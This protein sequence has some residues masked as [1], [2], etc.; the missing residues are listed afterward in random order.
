MR[1]E[2]QKILILGANGQVGKE[3]SR[4]AG[5]FEVNATAFTRTELDITDSQA[6]ARILENLR[7]NT[8]INAA[9]Y[10]A[11]DDAENYP[12]VAYK[13]NRDAPENLAKICE[14]LS[15][16][17]IHIST[18]Y[19]FDGEKSGAY[20]EDDPVRP[21]GI[22]GRSKEAGEAVIR[23]NTEKYIILRTSW[24]YAAHGNN[25]L[26]TM[27]RLANE[28][29]ELNIVDDQC[30]VPT[31]AVDIAD[32]LVLIAKQITNNT[33]EPSWGTFHYT[34]KNPTTWRGFAAVSYT[35]LRAHE[36]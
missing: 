12:E 3:L 6:V 27:M 15:I 8:V 32:A 35:H 2:K 18:D 21:L 9:A 17:I 23:D 30:G 14:K 5:N 28:R 22:Y 10:T 20:L 34:S 11:V 13:V 25:F 26:R 4:R 36:T 33:L 1:T 29:S 7:P 19:V 16:P 31:C 24:V